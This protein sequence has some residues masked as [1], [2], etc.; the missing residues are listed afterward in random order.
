MRGWL[1]QIQ[2]YSQCVGLRNHGHSAFLSF[3]ICL[4]QWLCWDS[5]QAPGSSISKDSHGLVPSP[6]KFCLTGN[7]LGLS[8]CI[9]RMSAL[10]GLWKI[11]LWGSKLY[12]WIRVGGYH[13]MVQE[14]RKPLEENPSAHKQRCQQQGKGR[15][16]AAPWETPC[17]PH[18]QGICA[19]CLCA[20]TCVGSSV[21]IVRMA[22]QQ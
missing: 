6:N 9:D 8:Y 1:F 14:A 5:P 16:W 3:L 22:A 18:S 13:T 20:P 2:L 21:R 15:S 19:G 12:S 7:E 10:L 11:R 17:Q 4:D